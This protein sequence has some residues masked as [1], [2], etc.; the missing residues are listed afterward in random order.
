MPAGTATTAGS[1]AVPHT[2]GG[3]SRKP[4]PAANRNHLV[5]AFST[6]ATADL[7]RVRS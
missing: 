7:G 6:M 5:L 2:V 1:A 3:L 4:E